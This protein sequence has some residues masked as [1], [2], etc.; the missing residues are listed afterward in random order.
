MNERVAPCLRWKK[1]LAATCRSN[2]QFVAHITAA[3]HQLAARR[4]QA[5]ADALN[6]NNFAL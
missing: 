2:A 3:W 1:S 4:A 6:F 5:I